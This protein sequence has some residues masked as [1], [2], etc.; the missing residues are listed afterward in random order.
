MSGS[1]VKATSDRH[2]LAPCSLH[3]RST[4]SRGS[5]LTAASCTTPL[6]GLGAGE[7]CRRY[8]RPSTGGGMTCANCGT[9]NKPGRKFCASCGAALSKTCPACGAANDPTDRFCG[10][11]GTRLTPDAAPAERAA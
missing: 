10:E 2:S 1:V 6:Q 7:P 9:E 8:A 5:M 3:T 4:A 11:C